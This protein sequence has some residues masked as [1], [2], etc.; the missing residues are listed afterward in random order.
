VVQ[1]PPEACDDGVNQTAYATATSTACAPGC[2][3]PAYCGDGTLQASH[4]EVC[5]KGAANSDTNNY[6]GCT[7]TCAL[8]PRCGDAVVQT[9]NGEVCDN[10][11][12]ATPYVRHP[13]STDCAPGCNPPTYCGDGKVD[14]PY[15][16]CDNGAGNT[17]SGAYNSCTSSCTLGPH[18]GDGVIQ[19]SEQCDDG[20]QVNGDGCSAACQK[21]G[22]IR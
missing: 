2:T 18:C 1:T 21:E 22:T 10:G 7:T 13:S 6:D 5:D 15:E 19:G 8:G 20:N 14:V 16:V 3:K 11:F 12:N 17:D 4:G 9:A